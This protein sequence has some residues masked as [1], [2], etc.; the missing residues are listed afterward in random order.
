MC[1]LTNT[2]YQCAHTDWILSRFCQIYA[3]TQRRSQCQDIRIR[4]AFIDYTQRTRPP[5]RLTCDAGGI[6]KNHAVCHRYSLAS[7]FPCYCNPVCSLL[8]TW[9]IREVQSRS[10]SHGR[11]LQDFVQVWKGLDGPAEDLANLGVR[12]RTAGGE[13]WREAGRGVLSTKPRM[14]EYSF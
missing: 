13:A 8:I 9:I 7:Q 5:Y 12:G 1:L 2:T 14:L 10:S 3:I 4:Q 11:L 6:S